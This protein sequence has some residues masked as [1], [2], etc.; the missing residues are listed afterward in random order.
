MRDE[1]E[2]K[3]TTAAV[4]GWWVVLAGALLLTAS[5][6]AYLAVV[7]QQPAWLL[8]M[9]GAD[10]SWDFVQSVWFWAIVA[11]KLVLWLMALVALW[12]TLWARGLRKAARTA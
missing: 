3:V 9:W 7:P 11:F 4:A 1:F 2:H 6:I 5:W 8:S 12:L 10:L